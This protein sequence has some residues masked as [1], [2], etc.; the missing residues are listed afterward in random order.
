MMVRN[1]MHPRCSSSWVHYGKHRQGSV[2][3]HGAKYTCDSLPFVVYMAIGIFAATGRA[4]LMYADICGSQFR[5][6]FVCSYICGRSCIVISVAATARSAL[7]YNDMCG[8]HGQG[9][10]MLMS[11]LTVVVVESLT[12]IIGMLSGENGFVCVCVSVIVRVWVYV[13]V[14]VYMIV[15]VSVI[16][17]MRVSESFCASDLVTVLLCVNKLVCVCFCV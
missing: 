3:R 12:H 4:A 1:H 6:M 10:H 5:A 2:G 15:W 13:C 11:C 7:I 14:Y 16:F 17:F 9:S 8:I